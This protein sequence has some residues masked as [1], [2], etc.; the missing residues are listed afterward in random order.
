MPRPELRSNG[1]HSRSI[2]RSPLIEATDDDHPL[3]LDVPTARQYSNAIVAERSTSRLKYTDRNDLLVPP[4]S[5]KEVDNRSADGSST[6]EDEIEVYVHRVNKS[7]TLPKIILQ[8]QIAAGTLR[9][10]NRLFA[11]DTI[12]FR[13]TLLLPVAACQID[14]QSFEDLSVPL[15][16]CKEGSTSNGFTTPVRTASLTPAAATLSND[17]DTAA[18]FRYGKY[19]KDARRERTT[20]LSPVRQVLIDA[21]GLVD[22]ARVPA[23][24]LSYFPP[25]SR[26]QARS[27]SDTRT[28]TATLPTT[29]YSD[30]TSLDRTTESRGSFETIRIGAGKVAADAFNG[31]QGLIRRIKD[32]RNNA[33]IDLIEL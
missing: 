13:D 1:S 2:A 5:T 26:Q 31:T 3:L 11:N 28:A 20:G 29:G 27:S 22:V 19:A 23:A 8:Y 7:D 24:S 9:R 25:A 33:E 16:D 4:Y 14:P 21:I 12:H 32:R 30:R 10:A 18:P 17:L 6:T 15:I